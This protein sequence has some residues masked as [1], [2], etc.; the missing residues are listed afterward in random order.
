MIVEDVNVN[1]EPKLLVSCYGGAANFT[2]TDELEREF[3]NGIGQV[4]ATKGR[5]NVKILEN[6]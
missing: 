6:E 3:M 2:M 5:L 4:A 1:D